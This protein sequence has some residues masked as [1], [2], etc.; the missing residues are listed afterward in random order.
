MSLD[1]PKNIVEA[2][3]ETEITVTV[4]QGTWMEAEVVTFSRSKVRKKFNISGESLDLTLNS[5]FQ[6]RAFVVALFYTS[7]RSTQFHVNE[8]GS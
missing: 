6:K 4:S 5:H 2:G 8:Q 3:N 7:M 1:Y